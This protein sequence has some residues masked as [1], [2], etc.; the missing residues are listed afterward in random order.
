MEAAEQP[1][2]YVFCKCYKLQRFFSFFGQSLV[3]LPRLECS[4]SI[5]AHTT[6]TSRVQAI[7][8][9]PPN[10]WVAGTTGVCHHAWLI[11]V[12][13]VETA[14]HYVGQAG[15]EVLTLWST[16]LGIP[17]CW[18][19]RYEQPH[20]ARYLKHLD[21]TKKKPIKTLGTI[22]GGY[23]YNKGVG[24]KVFKRNAKSRTHKGKFRPLWRWIDGQ[25]DGR[26]DEWTDRWTDGWTDGFRQTGKNI[27]NVYNRVRACVCVCVCVCV[28]PYRAISKVSFP[29]R[30]TS[31]FSVPY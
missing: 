21:V 23:L 8:P 20:R 7:L 4:G 28:S 6:S 24:K 31:I 22:L 2:I 26:M 14:F 29:S 27:F 15:L 13:L 16:R 9:Q 30:K 5:S 25:R 17:K 11:F 12:F 10:S 19:Y 18:D 1:V 3:L